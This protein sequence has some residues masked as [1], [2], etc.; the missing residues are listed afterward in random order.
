M[1]TSMLAL[2]LALVA[3]AAFSQTNVP[4]PA[5]AKSAKVKS[6]AKKTHAKAPA[7]SLSA[8]GQ[9]KVLRSEIKKERADFAAK[10]HTAKGERQALLAQERAELGKIATAPGKKSERKAARAAVRQKYVNLLKDARAQ[11]VSEGRML[12]ED[13]KSKRGMILKLRQ[14]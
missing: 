12:R 7:L 9:I 5:P 3:P 4:A 2:A 6:H 10:R 11:R 14:S 8:Q 1:K 13:I